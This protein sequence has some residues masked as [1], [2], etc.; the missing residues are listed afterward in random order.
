MVPGKGILGVTGMYQ[1]QKMLLK[2]VDK[3]KQGLFFSFFANNVKNLATWLNTVIG[4]GTVEKNFQAKLRARYNYF[5]KDWTYG[6][7][8]FEQSFKIGKNKYCVT[9]RYTYKPIL[10]IHILEIKSK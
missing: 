6:Y 4:P 8:P 10:G 2:Q 9:V 7:L 5:K 3:N 1:P